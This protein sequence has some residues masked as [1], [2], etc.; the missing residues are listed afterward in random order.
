[1]FKLT[2][3]TLE[4]MMMTKIMIIYVMIY[5]NKET[6]TFIARRDIC[7]VPRPVALLGVAGLSSP[8]QLFDNCFGNR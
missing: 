8:R 6:P 7:V 1:M 2:E 5:L 3:R 4:S